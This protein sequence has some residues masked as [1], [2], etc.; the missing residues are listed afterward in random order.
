[1]LLPHAAIKPESS[2][3]LSAVGGDIVAQEVER[4][5]IAL[6]LCFPDRKRQRGKLRSN[7]GE[8]SG[9][10]QASSRDDEHRRASKRK[11]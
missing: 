4:S 10:K 11:P 2:P 1:M 6:C 9:G 3:E 8:K 7:E 5:R